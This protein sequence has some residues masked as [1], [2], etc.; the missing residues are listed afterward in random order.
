MA[1]VFIGTLSI[2]SYRIITHIPCGT[3]RVPPSDIQKDIQ[4]IIVPEHRR[5]PQF[6]LS[7]E[8]SDLS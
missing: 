6:E 7:S 3:T 2:T 4:T 1:I 5:L 8:I